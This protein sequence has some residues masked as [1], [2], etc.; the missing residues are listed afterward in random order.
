MQY[1]KNETTADSMMMS[2]YTTTEPFQKKYKPMFDRLLTLETDKALLLHCSAGKDRTGIGA[3]LILYA[4]GVDEEIICQDYEATNIY[5]KAINDQF[6]KAMTAH[7]ASEKAAM[8]VMSADPKYLR[9]TF[10]TLKKRYGSV[11][12]FLQKEMGLTPEK[13]KILTNHYLYQ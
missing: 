10:D 4:L 11:D 5:R 1:L 3:A 2:L 12:S 8:I 13:I 9:A 7:G 6:I